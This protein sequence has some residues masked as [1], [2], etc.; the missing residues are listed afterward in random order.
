MGSRAWL[1][2]KAR[3]DLLCYLK[4]ITWE[5][6]PKKQMFPWIDRHYI[7]HSAFITFKGYLESGVCDT[8]SIHIVYLVFSLF[9]YGLGGY[10]GKLQEGS[11]WHSR[12]I[13]SHSKV[14]FLLAPTK[15]VPSGTFQ[16]AFVFITQTSDYSYEQL[17]RKLC[18]VPAPFLKDSPDFYLGKFYAVTLKI[19][20]PWSPWKRGKGYFP[21][22]MS[23]K[24]TG[25]ACLRM[26]NEVPEALK[27]RVALSFNLIVTYMCHL[28]S[29][30]E[31][32][33]EVKIYAE[34]SIFFLCI[35]TLVRHK[36]R[37]LYCNTRTI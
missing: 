19:R 31:Y 36:Q 1:T 24:R 18:P 17:G 3:L 35:S 25:L 12:E 20:Y 22:E 14:P 10:V 7:I 5:C 9:R 16:C 34:H 29:N 8:L 15:N 32:Q 6:E 37:K 30:S 2:R 26:R 28:S 21:C 23:M 13:Q 27:W 33:M 11:F 4:G